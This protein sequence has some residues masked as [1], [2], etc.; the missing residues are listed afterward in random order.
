[1]V[2]EEEPGQAEV[3]DEGELVVE[4]LAREAPVAVRVAV[5]LGERAVA[6]PA[7]HRDRRLGAVREVGI[8]VSELVRQVERAPRG[9]LGGARDG[10]AVVGEPLR[11]LGRREKNAL[12]VPAPLRLARLERRVAADRH[13]HVLQEGAAA[14]VRVGVAGR[15]RRHAERRRQVAQRRVPAHVAAL[16]GP[17]QLDVEAVGEGR[18]ER[19]REIRVSHAE[20][21]SGAAGEHDQA[22][23]QLGEDAGVEGGVSGRLRLASRRPRPRVRRGHEAAE[24]RVPALGLDEHGHVRPVEQRQLRARDRPHA[25]R[26]RRVRELERAVEPVVVGERE[27]LVAELGRLHGELLGER[28]AVEEGVRGVAVEL[29][30]AHAN[31]LGIDRR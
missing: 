24:V 21:A 7:Q 1:M 31:P 5:A 22:L 10:V 12:V 28:G 2:E 6:D 15:D 14:R 4:A 19:G 11:E 20:A 9:D 25:E 26:L 29:D 17:L 16:V 3:V 27:R 30:D 13:E 18:S 8:A 23:V